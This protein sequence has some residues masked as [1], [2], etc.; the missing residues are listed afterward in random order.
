MNNSFNF[1]CAL[2]YYLFKVSEATSPQ[3][4]K[5]ELNATASQGDAKV[6]QDSSNAP[7][8]QEENS[9]TP[10]ANSHSLPSDKIDIL[11]NISDDLSEDETDPDVLSMGFDDLLQLY[12]KTRQRSH[13]YRTK[14]LQ[15]K[16]YLLA[17]IGL[18]L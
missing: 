12:L 3:T 18:L 17:P 14:S 2:F 5:A 10:E 9:S 1:Y 6:S 11:H 8:N 16:V 13:V 7:L 4:P 15:V